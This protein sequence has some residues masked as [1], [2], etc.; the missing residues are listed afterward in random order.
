MS[1]IFKHIVLLSLFFLPLLAFSQEAAKTDK[2]QQPKT[3]RAQRKEAKKMWKEKR[4]NERAEKKKIKEHHKR[5]QTKE[6]R[7]RM[8]KDRK[9]AIRNNEHKREF[10][11]KRWFSKKQ[12]V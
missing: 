12:K 5:I 9:T 1:K 3:T 11:L 8:K 10:F 4:R 7:K 6:V 2:E